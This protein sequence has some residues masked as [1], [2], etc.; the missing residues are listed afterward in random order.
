[1]TV[2]TINAAAIN[3]IAKERSDLMAVVTITERSATENKATIIFALRTSLLCSSGETITKPS[4]SN[5]SVAFFSSCFARVTK[6]R[7][8]NTYITQKMMQR[9]HIPSV[10]L[11]PA[12]IEA[13]PMVKGLVMAVVK[14]TPDAIKTKEIA[15]KRDQLSA[16][17][18]IAKTG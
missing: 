2:P 3:T 10:T 1:M 5:F 18:S 6:K 17:Q 15:V 12:A 7:A 16:V 14:P 11:T 9:Y 4:T 13:V 8:V